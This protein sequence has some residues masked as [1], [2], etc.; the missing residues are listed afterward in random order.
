MKALNENGI[1]FKVYEIQV[2]QKAY[3]NEQG[4][5]DWF[6]FMGHLREP[7]GP[8]RRQLVEAIFDSIDSE[9]QGKITPERLRKHPLMKW[10]P[11]TPMKSKHIGRESSLLR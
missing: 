9:G 7:M 8:L 5:V 3:S 2:F 4:L 11:S 10:S 6:T 1:F